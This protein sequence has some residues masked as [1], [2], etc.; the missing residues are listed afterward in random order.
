MLLLSVASAHELP[1]RVGKS[2]SPDGQI[3]LWIKAE[4]GEGEAAGVAQ[5]RQIKTGRTLSTFHWSGFGV[6]LIAP[7]PPFQVFWRRDGLFFAIKYE[8]TRGWSTGEIYGRNREGQWLKVEKPDKEYTN[9]IKKIS[10]VTELYGKGCDSP[11]EWTRN[12][13]LVLEFLDRNLIYDHEDL[14][15]E[16]MV[17]LKVEDRRGRPLKTAKIISINQKSKEGAERALRAR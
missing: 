11:V 13:E 16:F 8:G 12:G 7:R 5:I 9:A 1:Y 10:G 2:R 15:K 6:Q 3:E 17:T 4:N 14:E